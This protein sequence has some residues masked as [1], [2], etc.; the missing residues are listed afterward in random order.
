MGNFF[1]VLPAP[2]TVDA[3]VAQVAGD[4]RVIG[5]GDRI[6]RGIA[7]LGPGRD[8]ALSFCD[9]GASVER[10]AA[11]HSPVVI[12][13]PSADLPASD[14]RTLIV[15]EDPRTSFIEAVSVLLPDVARPPE[16]AVGIHQ[17]ADVHPD[18]RIAG[19]ASIG[20]CVSIGAGTRV[21]PGAVI[22]SGS[23]I[24]AN[25]VIGPGTVIGWVGLAYHDDGQGVRRFFPHLAGVRIGNGVDIGANA[26]VCQGILSDTTIGNHVKVGSLV[27]MG[28]G[29]II[30][31]NVWISAATSIAGHAHVGERGLIGIGATIIDNVTTAPDVLI[32]A[33]SVVTRDA[34]AGEKLAGVPA[35]PKTTLRRFGPTPR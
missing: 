14:T 17:H 16:P 4:V 20:G 26:C 27:Y 13:A 29:A 1:R 10:I 18:A 6:I 12:A 24:G 11:S 35:Q 33:G 21:G 32:G 34:E 23:V 22:Y 5:K 19:S 2:V 25:C 8:D 31:D 9:A 28:H 30:D 7:A 3:L 15:V